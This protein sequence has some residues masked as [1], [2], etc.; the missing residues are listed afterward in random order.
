MKIKAKVNLLMGQPAGKFVRGLTV[1][2]IGQR[3][4]NARHAEDGDQDNLPFGKIKH[5]DRTP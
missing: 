4:S 1:E 2:E 5:E 3:E